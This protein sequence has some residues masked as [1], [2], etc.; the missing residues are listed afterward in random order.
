MHFSVRRVH[1]ISSLDYS[2][3][4]TDL[5]EVSDFCYIL[6]TN[7]ARGRFIKTAKYKNLLK[8]F[9]VIPMLL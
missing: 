1:N 3:F 9:S 2:E 8:I 7:G 4:Y 6:T 5:H